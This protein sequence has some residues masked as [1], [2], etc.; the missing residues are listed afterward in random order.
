MKWNTRLEKDVAEIRAGWSALAT[1]LWTA[2]GANSWWPGAGP[3]WPGQGPVVQEPAFVPFN[4]PAQAP[5]HQLHGLA[6]VNEAAA[7]AVVVQGP[8]ATL[9]ELGVPSELA[10]GIEYA[11]MA[12]GATDRGQVIGFEFRTLDGSNHPIRLEIERDQERAA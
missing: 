5:V 2:A 1:L 9:G 4:L 12:I 11:F 3:W 8:P 10:R 6:P 7:P